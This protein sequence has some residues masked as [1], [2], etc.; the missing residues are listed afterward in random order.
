MKRP[1]RMF[2]KR[3]IYYVEFERGRRQSLR[4]KD[5]KQAR[6]IFNEMEKEYLRGRLI[7]LE[8]YKRISLKDFRILYT[9]EEQSQNGKNILTGREGVSRET[10][11]M[12][13]KALKY[14]GDVIG[15]SIQL[16]AISNQKIEDF[17]RISRQKGTS[18]TSINSY[19]RHIKAA[20]SWAIDEGYLTK[21]PKIKMYKRQAEKPRVLY[22]DEI[23]NILRRAFRTDKDFGRRV[24]FHL[25]TGAR[26]R[27]GC[28]LTWPM[29]D[30]NRDQIRVIGKGNKKRVIPL[31]EPVKKIMLP[32]KKDLGRVFNDIH[33][34]TVS[35]QFQ[36]IAKSCGVKA[37]LHD[38]R[39]TCATYL[40]KSGIDIRI[41]QEILGHAEITTTTIYA[42]V[43][44]DM[45]KTE[46]TKLKFK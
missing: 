8:N 10:V 17:K 30:F 21:R 6:A 42:H 2:Q 19:L 31:L 12:D 41:V 23:R 39:H 26:R 36:E 16:R 43:L 27:E 20:L 34:D 9:G 38:L 3:E 4:T 24:F 32:V 5:E 13:N 14:F 45:M 15:D 25:W 7:Q 46:M 35:H 29:I 28:G 22:P 11:K 18:E 33:P 1:M 40:L 37:R 44:E